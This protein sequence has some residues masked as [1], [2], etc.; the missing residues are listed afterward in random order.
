MIQR[1]LGLG[2]TVQTCP[3]GETL[4][5]VYGTCAAVGSKPP[6]QPWG[7][8]Y[9]GTFLSDI[10]GSSPC[11]PAPTA[12]LTPPAGPATIVQETQPGAWTT[13]QAIAQTVAVQ[14]AGLQQFYGSVAEANQPFISLP[15]FALPSFPS[16]DPSTWT[17][18]TWLL[19]GGGILLA[20]W[21]L[22]DFLA[23]R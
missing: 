5:P 12:Q 19:V 21:I 18:G 8:W 15:S 4:D 14:K 17:L 2:Q 10:F 9:C 23:R 7:N 6:Q 1:A 16:L 3:P 11:Y 20:G 13:D 22:N